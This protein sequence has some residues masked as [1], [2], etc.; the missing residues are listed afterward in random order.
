LRVQLNK[1]VDAAYGHPLTA[2]APRTGVDP[3][4]EASLEEHMK[5]TVV[6][7]GQVLDISAVTAEILLFIEGLKDE[8]KESWIPLPPEMPGWAMDGDMF[9]ADLS[10]DIRTFSELVERPWALRDFQH[11]PRPYLTIEELQEQFAATR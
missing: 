6:V 3:H 9:T 4:Y 10:A 11:T 2:N 8:I 1:L 7:T 5:P